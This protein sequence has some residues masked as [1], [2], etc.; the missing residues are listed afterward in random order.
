MNDAIVPLGQDNHLVAG[1]LKH[2]SAPTVPADGLPGGRLALTRQPIGGRQRAQQQGEQD[3][4]AHGPCVVLGGWPNS[5]GGCA[6]LMPQC[7]MRLRLSSSSNGRKGWST[8]AWVR[9]TV[10]PPGPSSLP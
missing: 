9:K 1:L 4:H 6:S 10:L 5:H 8:G 3:M 7:S 2:L